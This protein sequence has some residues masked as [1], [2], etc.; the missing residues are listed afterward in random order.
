MLYL[1][2]AVHREL[3]Q[4]KK[5]IRHAIIPMLQAEEDAR[6]VKEVRFTSLLTNIKALRMFSP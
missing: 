1:S 2:F 5:D 6:F 4:E 3:R